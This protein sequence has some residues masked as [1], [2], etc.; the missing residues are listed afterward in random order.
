MTKLDHSSGLVE[1][2]SFDAV[3]TALI[4]LEVLLSLRAGVKTRC[5][6]FH[7]DC[8]QAVLEDV[9]VICTP[10]MS[11]RATM[12]DVLRSGCH[13][14]AYALSMANDNFRVDSSASL[15]SRRPIVCKQCQDPVVALNLACDVFC[16]FQ[17]FFSLRSIH[18]GRVF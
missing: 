16:E 18:R 8:R 5:I 7:G 14:G 2:V 10:F 1:S 6:C 11:H 9:F 4:L 17:S 15:S 12:R 13:L 3:S